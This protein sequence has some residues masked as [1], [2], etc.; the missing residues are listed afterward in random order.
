VV[1]A[2]YRLYKNTLY[3]IQID[4]G[5]LSLELSL[6]DLQLLVESVTS[7]FHLQA[8]DKEIDLNH[9]IDIDDL[10]SMYPLKKSQ[11]KILGDVTRL[12]QVL[13]NLI[14]NSLKFTPSGGQVTLKVTWTER[15]LI[16]DNGNK[17]LSPYDP[18]HYPLINSLVPT[19]M[20]GCFVVEVK[21]T[22]AGLSE[23]Q[24]QRIFGEGVQFNANVLQAGQGSGL[25]LFITAGI[26]AL[27]GGKITVTSAGLGKGTTFTVVLPVIQIDVMRVNPVA[28]SMLD[29][30]PG[31]GNVTSDQAAASTALGT[32]GRSG[33]VLKR[34]LV[35]D[36]SLPNRKM[37][38]RLLTSRG[39]EVDQ[40]CDG[41]EAVAKYEFSQS[42]QLDLEEGG[43][44]DAM[45]CQH[46]DIIL[47]DFE[48]PVM[49]GP[50]ATKILREKR[51]TSMIFG[52]TGNALPEDINFFKEHGADEVLIKPLKVELVE[53]LWNQ[54]VLS[55]E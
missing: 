29:A 22:G 44:P 23:E 16:G 33:R 8:I 40:A 24:L 19:R 32:T 13:R 3:C 1:C 10:L 39:Y 4:S 50:T 21:D 7:K 43:D 47:M 12:S 37:L 53:Q 6:I 28:E 14:S 54:L 26:V 31:I 9:L 15:N 42:K 52:L 46:Y 25:G 30:L 51:C 36:D 45:N 35:V 20:E 27:H 34:L 48:M 17:L 2:F 18:T 41:A 5:T 11:I 49:N 55:E 38:G